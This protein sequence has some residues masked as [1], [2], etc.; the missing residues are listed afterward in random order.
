MPVGKVW[1]KRCYILHF[2]NTYPCLASQPISTLTPAHQN[3]M[4]TSTHVL[5]YFYLWAPAILSYIFS[6]QLQVNLQACPALEATS[7]HWLEFQ[8]YTEEGKES[9]VPLGYF[10]IQ[11]EHCAWPLR[12][13]VTKA[14]QRRGRYQHFIDEQTKIQKGEVASLINDKTWSEP[15]FYSLQSPG[16]FPSMPPPCAQFPPLALYMDLLSKSNFSAEKTC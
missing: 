14:L 16:P 8:L 2:I 3:H 11:W 12:D 9:T 5:A 1:N 10:H 6:E 15:G 7:V 13:M 4:S